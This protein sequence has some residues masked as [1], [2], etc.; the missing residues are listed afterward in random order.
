G[1]GL[2]I[3]P[4]E[5]FISIAIGDERYEGEDGRLRWLVVPNDATRHGPAPD[6]GYGRVE[7]DCAGGDG[8]SIGAAGV[9][10]PSTVG[11][12][13]AGEQPVGRR[14]AKHVAV[15]EGAAGK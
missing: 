7:D 6:E 9:S 11:D 15:D 3:W 12:L 10:D 13:A 4:D 14:V 2:L 5:L 1:A 8:R